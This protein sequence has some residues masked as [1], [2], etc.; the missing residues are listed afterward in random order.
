[1]SRLADF[2]MGAIWMSDRFGIYIVM[3]AV[4]AAFGVYWLVWA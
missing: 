3:I 2:L 4:L 1:M